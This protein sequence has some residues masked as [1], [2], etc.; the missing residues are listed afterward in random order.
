MPAVHELQ[1]PASHVASDDINYVVM[2]GRVDARDG[3]ARLPSGQRLRGFGALIA[4]VPAHLLNG[5]IARSRESMLPATGP[6]RS[7]SPRT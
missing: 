3:P 1:G 6:R 2:A 5:L 4:R 7:P